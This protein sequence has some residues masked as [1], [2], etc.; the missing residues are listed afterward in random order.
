MKINRPGGKAVTV[1]TDGSS[2]PEQGGA[3]AIVLDARGV[4]VRMANRVLP[5][6]TSGEAEYAGLI[7]GMVLAL[8][9]GALVAEVR[10]DSEV[11]VKQMSG[12]YAVNSPRLRTSH[13]TACDLARQFARIAYVYVPREHN[14]LAAEASAGREWRLA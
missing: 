1:Y 11:V 9:A 12:H 6:Q 14:A 8:D 7:L 2:T 13:W 4:V 5:A 3:V 10:M